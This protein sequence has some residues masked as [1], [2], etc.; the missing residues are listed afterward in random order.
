MELDLVDTGST[1]PFG[2]RRHLDDELRTLELERRQFGHDGSFERL[3]GIV[4]TFGERARRMVKRGL[5]FLDPILELA[6]A[7]L[8]GIE[9]GKIGH[10]GGGKLGQPVDLHVEFS[11][12]SP[13]REEPLLGDLQFTGIEIGGTQGFLCGRLRIGQRIE[14]AVECSDEVTH[15][16]RSF[17]S[18]A[19]EPAHE[20]GNHRHG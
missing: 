14:R 17:L 13:E 1:R 9:I 11:C 7:F 15:Q 4:P 5:G 16:L 10:H 3:G 6:K 19:L 8:A 2:I 12:G 20:R 18:L